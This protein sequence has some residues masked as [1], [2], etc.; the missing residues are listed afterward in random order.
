MQFIKIENPVYT[1]IEEYAMLDSSNQIQIKYSLGTGDVVDGQLTNWCTI[2]SDYKYIT[3]EEME[4]IKN[5]PITADDVG[6]SSDDIIRSRLYDYLKE[7]G[8]III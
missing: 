1:V 5:A 3:G 8:L 2:I 6:K 4:A 7:K